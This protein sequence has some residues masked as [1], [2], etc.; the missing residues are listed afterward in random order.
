MK[1][2]KLLTPLFAIATTASVLVPLTSCGGK[3][4]IHYEYD[5]AEEPFEPTIEQKVGDPVA[6]TEAITTYLSSEE[7]MNSTK[8][9]QED[10]YMFASMGAEYAESQGVEY[11]WCKY[12]VDVTSS[13]STKNLISLKIDLSFQMPIPLVSYSVYENCSI[14][15]NNMEYI[16]QYEWEKIGEGLNLYKWS[17][18]PLP[19]YYMRTEKISDARAWLSSPDHDW[20]IKANMKSGVSTGEYPPTEI[21][22][23]WNNNNYEDLVTGQPS[24]LWTEVFW[25]SYYFDNIA[26]Q[27]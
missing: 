25:Q 9:I 26:K 20:S 18:I 12:S 3:D 4:G 2:I 15:V 7:Q 19:Y 23:T 21:K 24:N 5:F 11:D 10:Y 13:D 22:G 6:E 8:I 17:V 1:K 27:G 16:M 14:E